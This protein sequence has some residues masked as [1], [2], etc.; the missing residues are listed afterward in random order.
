MSRPV[1]PVRL[2]LQAPS[3]PR[4]V[5][6]E[7]LARM[8]AVVVEVGRKIDAEENEKTGRML[9]NASPDLRLEDIYS[10]SPEPLRPVTAGRRNV[11]FPKVE[12]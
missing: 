6:V 2:Q 9:S 5:A 12:K 11:P 7:R 1:L 10:T 4:E 3:L 8:L